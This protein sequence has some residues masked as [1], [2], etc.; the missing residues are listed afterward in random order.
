MNRIGYVAA[1]LLLVLTALS[2][3]AEDGSKFRSAGANQGLPGRYRVSVDLLPGDELETISRQLVATYGG[4]IE[5]YG[6]EGFVGFAV[7][8][9]ETRARLMSRD[10]RVVLVEEMPPATIVAPPP[11]SP[12]PG[13]VDA[14]R[15]RLEIGTEAIPGFGTYTYDGSG[16]ITSIGD[17]TGMDSFFYDPFGRL[18]SA[19]L[20]GEPCRVLTTGQPCRTQEYTYDDY[21][22]IV[23]ILTATPSPG[24]AITQTLG[25][26]PQTNQLD[27]ESVPNVNVLGVYDS[28]GNLVSYNSGQFEYDGLDLIT[29]ATVGGVQRIHVYNASDERVVTIGKVGSTVTGS[30]WTI[31]DA[32]GRVL[33]RLT[34]APNG[35]FTWAEDYV[36]RNGQLLAAAV[37]TAEKVRHFHLDHLGTPR[38][39]TGNGGAQIAQHHYSPFGVESSSSTNDGEKAK[40]TGH[41]RDAPTLDYMH[42]RYY[43][44][45]LGRFLSVDPE[46]ESVNLRVPQTWNRY[47]YAL[48]NPVLYVDPDG[49]AAAIPWG[50]VR[51]ATRVVIKQVG[52]RAAAGSAAGPVGVAAASAGLTGWEIGRAIGTS[53]IGGRTIDSRVT[54]LFVQGIELGIS[55]AENT[56]HGED[57]AND[58]DRAV[59]R[60]KVKGN[61]D[62]Y[63]DTDTGA[64]IYVH[65]GQVVIENEAGELVSQWNDQTAQE[66]R[67][68]ERDGKWRRKPKDQNEPE[69]E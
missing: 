41:E 22:N 25:V 19:I 6:E 18:Q 7:V 11:A 32:G 10:H 67:K 49:R 29:E 1:A 30:D 61:G 54:D 51:T 17:G 44:P 16:N 35:T 68:K 53:T 65:G 23:T 52:T 60:D 39:I 5:L 64:T 55:L 12:Q 58:P 15:P 13:T 43:D 21:G 9:S 20:R 2:A 3:L 34:R 50:G 57:R 62:V 24:V 56:A 4:R 37:P 66:T 47:S 38:L 31:R 26:D 8:L 45:Y 63:I 48:N 40:F 42:A 36:Y 69:I 46:R 27:N 33:R 59:D 14:V 28:R